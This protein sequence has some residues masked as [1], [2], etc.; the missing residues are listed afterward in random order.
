MWIGFFLGEAR[1][2]RP[3][4]LSSRLTIARI[5][6]RIKPEKLREPLSRRDGSA[7]SFVTRASDLPRRLSFDTTVYVDILQNRFP[8]EAEVVLR[9]ADA[10]HSPVTEAELLALCGLLKPDHPA[11]RETAEEL[12]EA[13]E[14]R[15]VHRA[16]APD[17]EVWLEAGLL[18]GVL[19]RLQ[20]YGRAERRRTLND[21][22]VFAT[23]RKHGMTVLTRNVVDFDLLQQLEPAGRVIFYERS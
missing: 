13:I 22:L 9:A 11:T 6:R 5:L 15:P 23:A 3:L 1:S 18:A 17:R 14:R 12:I 8:I 19:A 16:I 7:L 10:W 21:A 20:G 2:A 4:T